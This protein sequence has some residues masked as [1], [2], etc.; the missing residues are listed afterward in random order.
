[1]LSLESSSYRQPHYTVIRYLLG[2]AFVDIKVVLNQ[3]GSRAGTVPAFWPME[4]ITI[5][6]Q[7]K[8][9][10]GLTGHTVICWNE[11][12]YC[13]IA[14]KHATRHAIS[15]HVVN[16]PCRRRVKTT[17]PFMAGSQLLL[18]A[19]SDSELPHLHCTL[20]AINFH[21]HSKTGHFVG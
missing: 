19:V 14:R 11:T 10:P 3:L 6:F 4:H 2:Q 7:Q 13:E 12:M 17:S 20:Q 16:C 8:V 21:F 15:L 5:N 18:G 9:V 1:M